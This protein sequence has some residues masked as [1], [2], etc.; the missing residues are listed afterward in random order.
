MAVTVLRRQDKLE[1]ALEIAQEALVWLN[2]SVGSSSYNSHRHCPQRALK[3]ASTRVAALS[4][5]AECETTP[6]TQVQVVE[7]GDIWGLHLA[8]T[9][10]AQNAGLV[11]EDTKTIPCSGY[12]AIRISNYDDSESQ[13]SMPLTATVVQQ[14]VVLLHN[15]AL[16]HRLLGD[17][18]STVNTIQLALE[19]V[20]DL[21]EDAGA[22]DSET[23]LPMDE[24]VYLTVLVFQA[25]F[26]SQLVVE[27]TDRD[28]EEPAIANSYKSGARRTRHILK[29]AQLEA[30]QAY[31]QVRRHEHYLYA[32]CQDSPHAAAAA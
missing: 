8:M 4:H 7:D 28:A 23:I 25:L 13:A 22:M 29:M 15:K 9:T 3:D 14:Y 2:R 21:S 27:Y 31:Q 32:S 5:F 6:T 17:R 1:M 26:G 12:T 11:E 16:V 30:H 24:D 18:E 10:A 20:Q 19:M